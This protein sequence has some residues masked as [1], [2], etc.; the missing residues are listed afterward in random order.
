MRG[1]SLYGGTCLEI[2]RPHSRS[3]CALTGVNSAFAAVFARRAGRRI[4]RCAGKRNV[5]A[6]GAGRLSIRS[7][8]HHGGLDGTGRCAVGRMRTW[9]R[10][11]RWRP[12][13]ACSVGMYRVRVGGLPGAGFPAGKPGLGKHP[14]HTFRNTTRPTCVGTSNWSTLKLDAGTPCRAVG[15]A[16][17]GPMRSPAGRPLRR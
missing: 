13:R 5:A 9:A 12:T 16:S 14:S 6:R 1:V 2:A 8:S 11:S 3:A 10:A 4:P 17:K 15:P 7:S